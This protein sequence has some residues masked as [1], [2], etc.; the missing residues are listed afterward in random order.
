V[1]SA[2]L[3]IEQL[4]SPGKSTSLTTQSNPSGASKRQLPLHRPKAAVIEATTPAQALLISPM[5]LTAPKGQL[6][7]LRSKVNRQSY[8]RASVPAHGF[9]ASPVKQSNG[10]RSALSLQA[11]KL[12][13]M[14]S[15]A[16]GGG[17]GGD[18]GGGG[19]GAS[20]H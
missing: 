3:I 17:G 13:V 10:S 11:L 19:G 20:T 8:L 1:P 5:Q 16:G 7:K 2:Q 15:P 14:S 9:R 12:A 4:P 18:G 6:W